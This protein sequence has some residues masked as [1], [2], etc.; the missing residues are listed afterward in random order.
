MDDALSE[1]DVETFSPKIGDNF[2]TSLGVADNPDIIETSNESEDSKIAE[3]LYFKKEK[4]AKHF[5]MKEGYKEDDVFGKIIYTKDYFY[6]ATIK[7]G[8]LKKKKNYDI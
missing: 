7:Q 3:V 2:K 8:K 5:L 4:D 6:T 1:C